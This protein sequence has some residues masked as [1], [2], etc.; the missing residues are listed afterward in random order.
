MVGTGH[1]NDMG[2]GMFLKGVMELYGLGIRDTRI[3]RSFERDGV[4]FPTFVDAIIELLS[5][6]YPWGGAYLVY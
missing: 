1:R 5:F 2:M 3:W 6:L 4:T